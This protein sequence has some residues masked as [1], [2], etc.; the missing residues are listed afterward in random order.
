MKKITILFCLILCV[1]LC[2]CANERGQNGDDTL[3]VGSTETTQPTSDAIGTE[4]STVSPLVSSTDTSLYPAE[5]KSGR[6][7]SGYG[8]GIDIILDWTA[9]PN[10]K[11][12]DITLTLSLD[13]YSIFVGARNDGAVIIDGKKF[14]VVS[15]AQRIEENVRRTIE[16]GTFTTSCSSGGTVDVSAKWHFNGNYAGVEYE[17]LELSGSIDLK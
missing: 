17:W 3:G 5:P 1:L 7:T 4:T 14:T 12:Y 15:E 9:I 11:D 16:L 13:C 8:E 2:S 6:F 10:G